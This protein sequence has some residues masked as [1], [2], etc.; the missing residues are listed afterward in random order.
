MAKD[1]DEKFVRLVLP[2]STHNRLRLAAAQV[3]VSMAAFCAAAVERAVNEIV[4][5]K[6]AKK[7]K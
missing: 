7:E 3:Q 2:R 5:A 6:P 1:D 4:P